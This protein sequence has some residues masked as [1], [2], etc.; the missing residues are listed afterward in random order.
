[1]S[2]ASYVA[3]YEWTAFLLHQLDRRSIEV[4]RERGGA[5]RERHL[6]LGDPRAVFLSRFFNRPVT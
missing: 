3:S 5:L 1:M 2:S 6:R 4:A